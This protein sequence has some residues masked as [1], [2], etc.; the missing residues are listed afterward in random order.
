MGNIRKLGIRLT[1]LLLCVVSL[2]GYAAPVAA[3]EQPLEA[4]QT[5][6][7]LV[8]MKAD[9][10]S[11]AIG[12]MEDGTEITV[13]GTSGSFYKVDCYD[14]NGFILKSQ[15]EHTEDGKYY[16][17]CDPKSSETKILP[18]TDP[19]TALEMRHSLLAL[20][21]KQLGSRYV[22][23]GTTP[24]RFDCSGLTMYLYKQHG[25]KLQ[26]RASLQLS[27]GIVVPKEAM[28]VG[29]LIFFRHSGKYPADHVGIYAG[30][31]QMIHASSKRGVI[32]A[33][34]DESWH[35]R[36]FLCVRRII[37]TDVVL[38]ETLPEARQN[39]PLLTV[40]SVSGRTAP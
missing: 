26:R 3:V 22:Y 29:D 16:V 24:G 33:S 30:N 21:K 15:I 9:K 35:E 28:Q 1:A 17:N 23:G 8:R 40:N 32:Y 6:T 14:M 18:Y 27:D 13:L 31:N 34:L 25:I 36:N 2:A 11:T 5:Y 38:I 4:G 7:T 10:N 19:A 39:I 37:N 12:Q 20:A